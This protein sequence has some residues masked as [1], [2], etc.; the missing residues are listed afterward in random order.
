MFWSN[1]HDVFLCREFKVVNLNPFTFKKGS[2]QRSGMWEKI[3]QI[4]NECTVLR[5]SVD[6]RSVR[7]HMG[8]LVNK[9]KRKVRVEEKASGIAPDEPSEMENLLDTIIALEESSEA[10][11]QELRAERNEKCENDRAKAEDARLKAMEK[12]SE[13]RK[14]LKCCKN[15]KRWKEKK[16]KQWPNSSYKHNSNKQKCLK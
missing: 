11:S 3:A 16:W 14:S 6:K 10:E 1:E 5:F 2:T 12:L 15:S 8:I 4:L 9:H 7:D 13:T